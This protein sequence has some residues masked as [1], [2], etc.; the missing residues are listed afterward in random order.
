MSSVRSSGIV[1]G[2]FT[3]SARQ[4]AVS[5][6]S[7]I[8]LTGSALVS[9]LPTSQP[10]GITS[11]AALLGS[12]ITWSPGRSGQGG[13]QRA[14]LVRSEMRVTGAQFVTLTVGAANVTGTLS[15]DQ[16][17][18]SVYGITRDQVASSTITPA[19]SALIA[20]IT[21]GEHMHDLE[22]PT[23]FERYMCLYKASGL[24]VGDFTAAPDTTLALGNVS[25]NLTFRLGG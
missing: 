12:A 7:A 6:G 22:M 3:G 1:T 17:I 10:Y 8:L 2:C 16:E 4:V 11:V 13:S 23:D 24:L 19:N 25:V 15:I 21:V 14:T 18:V 5:G 20:A 9:A